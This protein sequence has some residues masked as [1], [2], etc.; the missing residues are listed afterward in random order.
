VL[1]KEPRQWGQ[2]DSAL[3]KLPSPPAIVSPVLPKAVRRSLRMAR[4]ML[5][6]QEQR[7]HAQAL[8]KFFR[9]NSYCLQGRRIG[10]YWPADG[11]LDVQ[12]TLAL[13][14]RL[15]AAIYLPM[16][17]PGKK[18]Q[19]LFVPYSAGTRLKKNRL[20]ISE[21][22]S[23]RSSSKLPWMLDLLLV[24][25]VGFDR[26]CNRIGMGG[27]FYDRTLAYIR[28]RK[29]WRRP[30]LIG[31]AHEC[32]RVDYLAPQPWDVPLDAVATESRLYRRFT[33][34]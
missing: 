16:L 18:R 25:L 15:G 10:A 32:Q 24:P 29:Y 6:P 31:I 34:G 12:P 14:E 9:R 8:R 22:T 1:V 21:P 13:A 3:P 5:S 7:A 33:N 30:R 23:D 27:G 17:R 11:E 19:L 2:F 26:D 20:G 4:R 28:Q